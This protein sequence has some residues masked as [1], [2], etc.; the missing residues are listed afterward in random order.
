LAHTPNQQ[1][2]RR[3]TAPPASRRVV[4]WWD[5]DESCAWSKTPCYRSFSSSRTT[6]C[7]RP[8][9][10][11]DR[12][13]AAAPAL[14]CRASAIPGPTADSLSPS[15]RGRHDAVESPILFGMRDRIEVGVLGATGVVGQQFVARLSRHPWFRPTWLAASERSEGKPYGRVA[16]WRLTTPIPD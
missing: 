2:R 14:D 5:V 12:H 7:T 8:D 10:Q 15:R 4:C 11:R 6:A 3:S 9:S 16:P 13:G 1:P